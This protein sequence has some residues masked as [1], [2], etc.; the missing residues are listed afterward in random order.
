MVAS[1]FQE[2]EWLLPLLQ[3]V[4]LMIAFFGP[5]FLPVRYAHWGENA[6]TA[7]NVAVF[8]LFCFL[9]LVVFPDW[10]RDLFESFDQPNLLLFSS[11]ERSAGRFPGFAALLLNL[12]LIGH[13]GDPET[14]FLFMRDP[15]ALEKPPAKLPWLIRL[16]VFSPFWG[17]IILLI[18]VPQFFSNSAYTRVDTTGVLVRSAWSLGS[19]K[20][21]ASE[22]VEFG[23]GGAGPTLTVKDRS[24]RVFLVRYF[25]FG[26]S[27]KESEKLHRLAFLLQ[28]QKIP[29][30]CPG[31]SCEVYMRATP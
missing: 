24:N 21:P 16:R 27:R 18:G 1:F 14:N 17:G 9:Y 8:L 11:E 23:L 2:Q 28:Q 3:G 5:W 15:Q 10:V 7:A 4:G 6:R 26:P 12:V 29:L 19:E 30:S 20:I 31:A 13:W 22:I 25:G